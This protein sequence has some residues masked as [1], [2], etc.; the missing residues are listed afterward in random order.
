MKRDYYD[1]LAKSEMLDIATECKRTKSCVACIRRSECKHVNRSEKAKRYYCLDRNRKEIT[2]PPYIILQYIHV[3]TEGC[4]F[5]KDAVI[6]IVE[7]CTKYIVSE[8]RDKLKAVAMDL[9]LPDE[10]YQYSWYD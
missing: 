1:E 6:E 9:I 2:L 3:L 10:S 4:G 8:N 5:D 7:D